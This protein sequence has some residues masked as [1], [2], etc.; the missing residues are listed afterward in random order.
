MIEKLK[1][2]GER[3][4]CVICEGYEEEE[5]L[6]K[7]ISLNVFSNKYHIV[8]VNAK[9]INNIASRYQDKF[10]S[11]SYDLVLIL[12]DTD[13]CP[14]QAYN[15]LKLKIN[16]FHDANVANDIIIFGNPC[17]MQI[18]LSHFGQ[19]KLNSH[20]KSK[21]CVYIRNYVG[22]DT[23]RATAEQRQLLFSKIKRNN[24]NIMKDNIS[25][26]SSN[27][28]VSPSTNILAFLDKLEDNNDNWINEINNKI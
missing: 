10:Q 24:Y 6:E 7:L 4:L 16:K 18:I 23:Y 13:K 21:N 22:I 20:N 5:Y 17:T 9:S 3:R 8:K 12:C 19:I 25:K 11:G 14:S 28:N 15:E 27:D 2:K 26:L 1:S